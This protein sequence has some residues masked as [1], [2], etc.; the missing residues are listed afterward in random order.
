VIPKSKQ[1]FK[2]AAI[3]VGSALLVAIAGVFALYHIASYVPREQPPS[4]NG[5]EFI[6]EATLQIGDSLDDAESLADKDLE[7]YLEANTAALELARKGLALPCVVPVEFD[8]A[9]IAAQT[10]VMMGARDLGHAFATEALLYHRQGNLDRALT[11]AFDLVRLG[12]SIGNRGVL[13]DFMVGT[14]CE[15]Q[16]ACVISNMLDQL[17][18]SQCRLTIGLLEELDQKRETVDSL[19]QRERRWS[20]KSGGFL[21]YVKFMIEHRSLRPEKE[22]WNSTTEVQSRLRV[23][24]VIR[25]RIAIRA[26]ELEKGRSPKGIEELVP[27]YLRELPRDPKNDTPLSITPAIE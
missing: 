2:A 24:R 13:I 27:D 5:Y 18:A 22:V 6:R 16:G 11:S 21:E 1:R 9:W 17:D 4:L 15:I 19:F 23:L 25:V 12:S 8:Q 3:F 10:R 20:V 7:V 14:A 26:F